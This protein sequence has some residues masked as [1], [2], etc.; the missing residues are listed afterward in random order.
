MLARSF[1]RPLATACIAWAV[2]CG[3]APFAEP[4][5]VGRGVHVFFG[6]REEPSR[7]TRGACVA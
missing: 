4:V 3:G 7:A 5:D 1:A 2:E 6:A